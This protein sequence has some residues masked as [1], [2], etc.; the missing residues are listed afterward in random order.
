MSE[1][2]EMKVEQV[3]IFSLVDPQLPSDQRHRGKHR[4]LERGRQPGLVSGAIGV[5][6]HVLIAGLT[7]HLFV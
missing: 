2:F 5:S 3:I 6:R 1:P 4:Y 7:L